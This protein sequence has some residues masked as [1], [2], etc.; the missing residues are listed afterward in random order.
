MSIRDKYA[1]V[2]V[3]LTKLGRIPEKNPD[4]LAAEAIMLALEDAGMKKNEP[5]RVAYKILHQKPG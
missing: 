4:E 2:G 1:I 3:G 5:G